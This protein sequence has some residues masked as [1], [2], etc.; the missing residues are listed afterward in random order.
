MDYHI[1]TGSTK[2]MDKTYRECI[3]SCHAYL[4]LR[5]DYREHVRMIQQKI[6]FK[7]I[8]FH[9]LF[10]DLVGIYH[11]QIKGEHTFNFQNM[12]K[13]FDFFLSIGIKPFVELGQMPK[14]LAS[15]DTTLFKYASYVSP[16]KD[17]EVWKLLVKET[18]QAIVNRYGIEEAL[19][20]KFEVWNEP[21]LENFWAGT[22]EEYFKLYKYATEAVKSVHSDLL[23]GGPATS[24]CMWVKDMI[25]Y[26]DS[27]K[28]PLDFITTHHYSCD[29]SFDAGYEDKPIHFRGQSIMK[30]EV[31]KV[32]DIVQHSSAKQK[33]IHFTEW[34]VSPIHEDVY[35]KDSEYTA[36]FALSTLRDVSEYV[37]SYS[38]WTITDIFEESG[39][40][41]D[42]F[43]GKYGFVNI[44][45]IKKPI[46][47]AY[48]FLAQLHDIEITGADRDTIVTSSYNSNVNILTWNLP[49]V[50]QEHMFGEDYELDEQTIQ[51]GITLYELTNGNYRILR[52]S[53]N[54]ENANA[55]TSWKKMGSPR[56]P[57]PK[58]IDELHRLSEVVCLEDKI[59]SINNNI[60]Q[61][62][63]EL[64]A[65][66]MN[67]ISIERIQ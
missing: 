50:I 9:G 40:S 59:I 19:T 52:Y 8:R 39:P 60:L 18:I 6:G 49:E 20:W 35:A 2:A 5:E 16:P 1:K 26:C 64:S 47:H 24:K 46:F 21:D 37:N 62:K 53:V 7:Q 27:N 29:I 11:G 54:K 55:L 65:A 33:P 25:D 61:L 3:G 12:Y 23:V 44:H 63:L 28:V 56:Y 36:V 30:Q 13:I 48:H 38:F 51:K 67:F 58:Q 15:G 4:T 22:Q 45:G 66:E 43:T 41:L 17:Y 32:Y 31:Q 14:E 10:H 42:P 34:N 57:S